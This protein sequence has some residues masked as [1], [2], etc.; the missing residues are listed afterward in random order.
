MGN[1]AHL[2]KGDHSLYLEHLCHRGRILLLAFTGHSVELVCILYCTLNRLQYTA[3]IL[4]S[5]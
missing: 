1:G 5:W 2:G 4:L 3:N